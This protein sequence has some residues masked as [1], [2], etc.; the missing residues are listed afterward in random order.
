MPVNSFPHQDF[1]DGLEPL[2]DSLERAS[3]FFYPASSFSASLHSFL[4]WGNEYAYVLASKGPYHFIAAYYDRYVYFPTPPHP[5]TAESLEWV[6]N[7]MKKVNGPGGGISRVEG[8]TQEQ[9]AEA[10]SWG[11]RARPTLTEYIYERSRL[12]GLHGDPFRAKRAEI[13]HFLKQESVVIRPYR[14]TDLEACAELFELWK[15]QRLAAAKG[16][17]EEKML[18]SS[19]KAHSQVL[20]RG[21][22]WG[23]DLWVVLLGER[24]VAYTAGAPLG[25]DTYGVFLEVT[26]LTVKGLSSYIFTQVCRQA[27]GFPFINTGDAEGLSTLAQSKEHW[28]PSRKAQIYAVD[29][30]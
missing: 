20:L 8:M 12:A 10:E 11:Y 25:Q 24:L 16:E 5:L 13:N 4:M 19:Q 30:V 14:R 22:D 17:M 3:G 6:F 9:S 15:S 28:H 29:P 21:R 23:M 18:R 7:F 2:E 27:E 1:F 26:D